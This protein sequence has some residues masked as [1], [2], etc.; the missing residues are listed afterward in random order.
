MEGPSSSDR[1]AETTPGARANSVA[2]EAQALG[3]RVLVPGK[4]DVLVQLEGLPPAVLEAVGNTG[5][6]ASAWTSIFKD[7]VPGLTSLAAVLIS[8]AALIYTSHQK[9]V[10]DASAQEQRERAADAAKKKVLADLI[11]EFGRTAVPAPSEVDAELKLQLTAMNIAAYGDQALQA[12]RMALGANDDGLRHGG[13]LVAEQMY[14]AETVE[15]G[16]LVREILG[17]YAASSPVLR[18]GVLEWLVEMGRQLSD[19]ESRLAYDM[20]TR[21]FGSRAELCAVQDEAVALQAAKFLF[22]WSLTDSKALVFGM[23]RE[24][25]DSGQPTKFA[26]ARESAVETIPGIAKSLS[27]E[28]RASI[29]KEDLPTLRKDAPELG[30]LIDQAAASI[31]MQGN[32]R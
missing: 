1:K 27:P 31:R 10:S 15:H 21:S 12:V 22:I 13:V 26:A 16:K 5:R 30:D 8:L 18:R 25:R 2:G 29:L 3:I 4:P 20:L 24:C 7:V 19:E 28:D 11:K 17:Y 6:P 32:L 9:N 14:R 23:A